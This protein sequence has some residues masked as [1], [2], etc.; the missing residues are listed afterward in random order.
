MLSALLWLWLEWSYR[1]SYVMATKRTSTQRAHWERDRLAVRCLEVFDCQVYWQNIGWQGQGLAFE[2]YICM[3]VML[4]WVYIQT[5]R[6]TLRV[7]SQTS[8][9]PA[10]VHNT[11]TEK[12][13][14]CMHVFKFPE[15]TNTMYIRW[16]Y[17]LIFGSRYDMVWKLNRSHC[18]MF[19][20]Q[21]MLIR[22]R[23]RWLSSLYFR[24]IK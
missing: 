15:S 23:S 14:L 24:T 2:V 16:R 13:I 19:L 20:S 12:Y 22:A 21:F 6:Y 11:N 10:W 18:I 8:Y 3:F 5:G 9:S 7:T 4:L 17:I 1:F